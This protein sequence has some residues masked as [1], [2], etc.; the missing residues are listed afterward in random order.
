MNVKTLT[1]EQIERMAE[2]YPNHSNK[3][4]AGILG[5]SE[6]TV[7]GR[8]SMHGWVK[9]KEYTRNLQREKAIKNNAQARLN[10]PESYAKRAA[11]MR[12]IHNTERIRIKWGLEQQTK[13]HYRLESLA[14]LW[15]RNRLQRLGYIID[16]IHLIAYYTPRTHRATRLEAIPRGVKKGSIR[17]YYDFRAYEGQLD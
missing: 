10:N 14:K 15:Q 2:L 8:A 4:I 5:V 17:P 13:R 7:K 12:K 9:S 11:T 1:N 16:E 6:W 3:E